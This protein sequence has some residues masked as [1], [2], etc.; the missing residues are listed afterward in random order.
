MASQL[1]SPSS[2]IPHKQTLTSSTN[3]IAKNWWSC[4]TSTRTSTPRTGNQTSSLLSK[5]Q[6]FKKQKGTFCACHREEDRQ[7]TPAA[8][9]VFSCVFFSPSFPF[10]LPAMSASRAEL[11]MQFI[12]EYHWLAELY[13]VEFYSEQHALK[14]PADW[15]HGFTVAHSITRQDFD[16]F[17]T[18]HSPQ[19][20]LL[21]R[22]YHCYRGRIVH[23]LFLHFAVCVNRSNG[24]RT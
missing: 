23:L 2:R 6:T 9:R 5:P 7:N 8:V 20:L 22:S 4:S 24:P 17:M 11:L 3:S 15:I 14:F 18:T 19:V 12:K 16:A 10:S 21:P 1:T 13:F